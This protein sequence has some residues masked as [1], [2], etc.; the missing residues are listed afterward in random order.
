MFFLFLLLMKR[1]PYI[2]FSLFFYFCFINQTVAGGFHL[3]LQGQKQLGMAHCGTASVFDASVLFFNPGAMSF[4]DSTN[5]ICA[6]SNFIFPRLAYLEPSPGIYTSEMVKNI[7]T[8]FSF[9]AAFKFKKKS[10]ISFAVFVVMFVTAIVS[11]KKMAYFI[12]SLS[13]LVMY[14][15][16]L[17]YYSM[18]VNSLK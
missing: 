11:T 7:S 16:Y 8:P 17:L 15:I 18:C 10:S 1:F 2:L 13:P 12:G 14:Y 9:Y 5:S 4:L 6:G 3:N